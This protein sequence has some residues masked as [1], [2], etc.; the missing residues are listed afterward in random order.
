MPNQELVEYVKRQLENGHEATVVQE[1]LVNH[2]HTPEVAKEAI[3]AAGGNIGSTTKKF[4]PFSG[5][6][7]AFALIGL[8]LLGGLGFGGY[9]FFFATNDLAGAATEAVAG[10]DSEGLEEA[11]AATKTAVNEDE[12]TSA[13]SDSDDSEGEDEEETEEEDESD[14]DAEEEE[15][16]TDDESEEETEDE[17]TDEEKEIEEDDDVDEGDA[18]P[19]SCSDVTDCDS[20]EACYDSICQADADKD[21]LPDDEEDTIGTEVYVQDSDGDG[22]SDYEEYVVG[23]NPLDSADPGYTECTYDI[24]CGDGEACTV[25]GICVACVDDDGDAYKTHGV[26]SGVFYT[27]RSFIVS[28]DSCNSEDLLIEY[29]CRSDN[30][31]Y[32]ST[33]DCAGEYGDG[34]TC[35]TG[36]CTSS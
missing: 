32:Y 7:I 10:S 28:Q 9:S 30:Y 2:G 26:T 11:A 6:A 36:K 13:V 23:T 20:G 18:S 31:L 1:H 34:Y 22:I 17:E 3:V 29:H 16:E 25:G 12:D 27:S 5:K 19:A 33:I 21:M 35:S 4:T 15:E 8:V 14:G 24:D